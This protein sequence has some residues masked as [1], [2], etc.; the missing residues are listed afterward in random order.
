MAAPEP[1]VMCEVMPGD[2]ALDSHP[3]DPESAEIEAFR[4]LVR[5]AD[6]LGYIVA[7]WPDEVLPGPVTA[8]HG[9]H[10][11]DVDAEADLGEVIAAFT[12]LVGAIASGAHPSSSS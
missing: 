11:I 10:V 12:A 6:R 7:V 8:D 4:S 2:P 9:A 3:R 1:A 5:Q